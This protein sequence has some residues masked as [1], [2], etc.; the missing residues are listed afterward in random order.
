M[1]SSRPFIPTDKPRFWVVFTLAGL[2]GLA[3]GLVAFAAAWSDFEALSA[4]FK[5]VFVICWAVGAFS[6]V[7]FAA[8]MLTGKYRGMVDR[9][10]KEQ[11]W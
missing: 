2:V 11:L 4:V 5:V 3:A 6:W 8:G 10:W 1:S 9:P 7:G